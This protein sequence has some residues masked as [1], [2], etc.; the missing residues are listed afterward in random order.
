MMPQLTRCILLS[1]GYGLYQTASSASYLSAMGTASSSLGFV[2]EL[3][4]MTANTLVSA[5]LLLLVMVLVRRGRRCSGRVL[6]RSGYA[7]I[8]VATVAG[9][10]L[11]AAAQASAAAGFGQTATVLLGILRGAGSAC[12][13]L[14]WFE[15]L[16]AVAGS[17]ALAVLLGAFALHGMLGLALDAL[18]ETAVSWV[19][20]ALLVTSCACAEVLGH[21]AWAVPGRVT[22]SEVG[23]ACGWAGT[24]MPVGAGHGAVPVSQGSPRGADPACQASSGRFV[25]FGSDDGRHLLNA[26]LCMLVCHFVVGIANTAVFDSGF[27]VVIA[28]VN[29]SVC[30]LAATGVVGVVFGLTRSAPDPEPVFRVVMPILLLI[31]SLMAIMADALGVVAGYLMISC[32]EAIALVYSAYLVSFLASGGYDPHYHVGL[33]AGVSNLVLVLGFVIGR[34]LNAAWSTHGVPLLTLLAFVAIYPLGLAFMYV[35]RNRARE[36]QDRLHQQAVAQVRQAR[37]Q[38]VRDAEQAAREEAGAYRARLEDQFA[39]RYGLTRREAQVCAY[40]TRG[41]TVRTLAEELGIT[42]NT[43]WTHIRSVYAKCG[44]AS[45]Q[46]LIDLFD[47]QA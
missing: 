38:A 11:P 9:A 40:L 2:S 12:A 3:P 47:A 22:A 25:D 28:G 31:F 1:L 39:R 43:A 36:Q 30:V 44:V 5:M 32:Y 42:E 20:V 21:T 41:F 26:L 13:M 34:L 19:V 8:L 4:F 15:L 16:V 6:C 46:E 14:A 27:S 33:T 37:E 7:L 18:P 29:V 24:T 23:Q 10:V 35:Q 17:R 45:K